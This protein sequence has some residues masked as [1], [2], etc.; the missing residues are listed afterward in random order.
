MNIANTL[1]ERL[2][3]V[4]NTPL[5]LQCIKFFLNLNFWNYQAGWYAELDIVGKVDWLA[6][7][8]YTPLDIC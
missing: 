7:L 1:Y 6:I 4:F 2:E 5:V 3:Y 8:F